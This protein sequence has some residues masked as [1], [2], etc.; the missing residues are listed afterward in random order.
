MTK[1]LPTLSVL[2]PTYNRGH[3]LG[4]LYKSIS[5]LEFI[6]QWIV[7]DDGSTDQ[8]AQLIKSIKLSIP[9]HLE[10]DY[11][12][13]NNSGMKCAMNAGFSLLT[14]DYF[15]KVDS[16]DYLADNFGVAY[17]D[18]I[19]FLISS[20]EISLYHHLSL[21]SQSSAGMR[22]NSISANAS[23]HRLHDDMYI[24]E[25]SKDRLYEQKVSGDLMDIF[26][27]EPVRTK[28]RY[29]FIAGGGH[30]P[31]GILHMFYV[32]TFPDR[33]QLFFDRVGICKEYLPNGITALKAN[34]LKTSPLYYLFS[35][36]IELTL[37]SHNLNSYFRSFRTFSWAVLHLL[38]K[39]LFATRQ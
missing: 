15:V 12:Y 1:A 25:Y 10:L 20:E 31:T 4:R 29:P 6:R 2:T 36:S 21:A 24:L 30:C 23:S 18:L 39:V 3:L 22:L 27:V 9:S 11:V 37:P 38:R 34:S 33:K 19:S 17:A 8:T 26:E 7:V 28:F 5:K 13:I 32:L 16:D 14:S 35:A